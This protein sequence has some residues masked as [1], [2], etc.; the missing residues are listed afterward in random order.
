MLTIEQILQ[1]FHGHTVELKTVGI[2]IVGRLNYQPRSVAKETGNPAVSCVDFVAKEGGGMA[3]A[4]FTH[5]D[6]INIEITSKDGDQKPPTIW[7]E[8]K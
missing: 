3:C 4:Q 5:E 8:Y 6:V 7:I 2:T 1:K